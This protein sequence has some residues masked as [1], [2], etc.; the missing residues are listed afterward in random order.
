MDKNILIKFVVFGCLGIVME[1]F[2]TG[3]FSFLSGDRTLMGYTSIWM[4]PIYGSAVMFEP[5]YECIKSLPMAVR[6]SVYMVLIFAAEFS[7]G[8]MLERFVGQCPW[9]YAGCR[10]NIYGLIRLDYA[11][12]WFTVGLFMERVFM[13]ENIRQ[14]G[15]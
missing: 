7:S 12:L 15:R 1:V 4:F 10:T 13:I 6:G 9:S 14:Q 3:L 5:I 11:P 8:Y 2:W